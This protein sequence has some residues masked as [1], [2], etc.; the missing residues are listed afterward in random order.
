[1]KKTNLMFELHISL[2]ST[3]ILHATKMMEASLSKI[4]AA[5]DARLAVTQEYECYYQ[6]KFGKTPKFVRKANEDVTE[7][8]KRKL[9]DRDI[10]SKAVIPP[11][12]SH[13]SQTNIKTPP[14]LDSKPVKLVSSELEAIGKKTG[15]IQKEILAPAAEQVEDHYDHKLLKP[16]P[17]YESSELKELANVITRDIYV[18]NPNVKWTDISGLE[19][20]KR[21]IKEA[22]VF[23]MKFPNLFQGLLKPWKGILLYG[24]DGLAKTNE[25]VFLLAASNLPWDLDNAMLRRLEKRILIDLPD[26]QAREHLFEKLLTS[27]HTSD[28][29]QLVESMDYQYLGKVTEGYSGSDINLVCREAAMRPLRQIFDQLDCSES[30]S[31][32]TCEMSLVTLMDVEESIKSTKPTCDSSLKEKYKE[33]QNNFGSV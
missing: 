20:S 10:S 30:L 1:M 12:S 23:P 9:K 2:S 16:L 17:I 11:I 21:L 15:S 7:L 26:I 18:K 25:H 3:I 6:I 4:K 33:W 29:R 19:K 32:E 31:N 28:G 14:Q 5:S 24:M 27:H 13:S 8:K 22:I